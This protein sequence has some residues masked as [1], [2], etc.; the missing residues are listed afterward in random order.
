[1]GIRSYPTTILYNGSA[2][3]KFQGSH[4]AVS[5]MEFVQ[6][7]VYSSAHLNCSYSC[8]V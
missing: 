7:S 4:D 3:H 5:I 1:M 8:R 2:T 6:V